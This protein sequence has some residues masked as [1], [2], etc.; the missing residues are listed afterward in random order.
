MHPSTA[1][2]TGAALQV[3]AELERGAFELDVD[4]GVAAGEVLGVLGPNGA[5]KTTLLRALAGLQPLTGGSIYLDARPLDDVSAGVFLPSEQRPVGI[6]FQNYRLFPHLSVLDNV[7]FGPR[8]RGVRRA[9]ARESARDQLERFGLAELAR[10]K[11]QQL[12][13]GQA[14][15]VALA[16]ALAARPE[17]LL[18]DEP[19]S[20]LDAQTRLAVRTELRA[21]LATFGGPTLIVTHDPLEA[22]ILTDRLLVLERGRAVQSGSPADVARRPTTQYIAQLVG[23]NLY[24]GRHAAPGVVELDGG[25]TFAHAVGRPPTAVG[26]ADRADLDTDERVLVAVRPTAIAL[27]TR[28]PQ[29]ASPRNCWRGRVTGVELLTDR[30]R[31]QVDGQPP[32]LVDVTADAVAALDIT[33]GRDVWL[34]AKATEVDVYADTQPAG[35]RLSREPAE[36]GTTAAFARRASRKAWRSPDDNGRAIRKP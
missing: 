8:S 23:L 4:F 31:I 12:S 32:A 14:Q 15:R 24:T 27:H 36:A 28:R 19:L 20:A 33:A 30:V 34:T 25:G 6:V 1:R 29:Q 3:R 35:G 2:H 21:H 16:R 5:G 13:G 22:M 9:L 11:P 26:G 18:L 7:A 10:H 17:V